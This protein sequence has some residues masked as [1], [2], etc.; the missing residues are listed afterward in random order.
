MRRLISCFLILCI[1]NTFVVNA[2]TT[3]EYENV[4][5]EEFGAENLND[6]D[7]EKEAEK[8][9]DLLIK[10]SEVLQDFKNLPN[11]IEL[12][13]LSTEDFKSLPLSEQL[14]IFKQNYENLNNFTLGILEDT[15]FNEYKYS[16]FFSLQ[17]EL[18]V[19][20]GKM[21]TIAEKIMK[22][23]SEDLQAAIQ[24]IQKA[25]ATAESMKIQLEIC[26]RL[27]EE[28]LEKYNRLKGWAMV[29]GPALFILG[30]V[31]GLAISGLVNS[32]KQ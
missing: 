24:D 2:T 18:F 27:A 4:E 22:S 7:F 12:Q 28:Q 8:V 6:E 9:K 19:H 31:G 20:Y 25:N 11:E 15:K 17:S 26:R 3:V 10:I 23:Q 30:C 14:R 1:F 5:L 13:D 32:I 21:Y 29:G 16:K